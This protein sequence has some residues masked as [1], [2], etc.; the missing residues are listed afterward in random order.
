MTQE[1]YEL[2][3]RLHAELHERARAFLKAYERY[4]SHLVWWSDVNFFDNELSASWGYRGD[5]E[6]AG[7]VTLPISVLLD[8]EATTDW[9]A[10]IV[11][12]I[13]NKKD[14]EERIALK[15]KAEQE[16]EKIEAAKRTLRDAGLYPEGIQ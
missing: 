6:Y 15:R 8:A 4:L 10:F 5:D 13:K 9:Y 11:A 12:D 14:E 16:R 2:Y 1:E 3:L 7:E